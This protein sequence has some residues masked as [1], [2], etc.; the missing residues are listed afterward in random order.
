M[1]LDHV[2]IDSGT[3][4]PS[5]AAIGYRAWVAHPATQRAKTDA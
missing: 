2:V 3:Y 4:L 1:T 5:P